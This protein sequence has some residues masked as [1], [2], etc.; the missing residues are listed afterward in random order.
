MQLWCLEGVRRRRKVLGVRAVVRNIWQGQQEVL[1]LS[2]MGCLNCPAE[3]CR[4][5]GAAHRS[6]DPL[7][8]ACPG[9]ETSAKHTPV[10]AK[11]KCA[12][13]LFMAT[14]PEQWGQRSEQERHGPCLVEH[15]AWWGQWRT[16]S[17]MRQVPQS[18]EVAA[19]SR[20]C[21][22]AMR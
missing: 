6:T 19:P 2:G 12:R 3:H 16:Q 7:W 15:T 8:W 21:S 5:L 18:T 20:G 10:A 17:S 4:W 1:P 9:V 11:L 14:C 13:Y 22:G